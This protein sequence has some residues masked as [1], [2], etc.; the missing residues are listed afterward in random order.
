MAGSKSDFSDDEFIPESILAAAENAVKESLPDKSRL[1][2]Q[3]RYEEFIIWK[4][5]N[6]T[7]SFDEKVF[8]AYFLNLSHKFKSSTL[9]S[10]FSMLKTIC[11]MDNNIDIGNYKKL[12][13]FIKK[14]HIGHVPKKAKIFTSTEIKKFITEAPDSTYLAIKVSISFQFFIL[15][16]IKNKSQ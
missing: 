4:K 12:I 16:L 3:S 10:I 13:A 15:S 2:Y 7:K 14:Q 8:L 9:W 11:K 5:A 6:G 1:I